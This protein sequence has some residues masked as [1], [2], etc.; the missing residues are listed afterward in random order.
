MLEVYGYL[1]SLLFVYATIFSSL[2]YL[3]GFL[4]YEFFF[5]FPNSPCFLWHFYLGRYHLVLLI[6]IM[7]FHLFVIIVI[8]DTWYWICVLFVYSFLT[9]G[10][11]L[12]NTQDPDNHLHYLRTICLHHI[13]VIK[14]CIQ[15]KKACQFNN[16]CQQ[17]EFGD[18]TSSFFG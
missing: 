14:F 4:K 5:S 2:H 11:Y 12:L 18:Y 13:A 8:I 16:I 6:V 7:I 9:V 10:S 15:G 17:V 3:W 1:V